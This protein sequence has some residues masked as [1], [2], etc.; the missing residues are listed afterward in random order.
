MVDRL[1]GSAVLNL[2]ERRIASDG[3][4]YTFA[5]FVAYYGFEWG[6]VM[7]QNTICLDNAEQP[8][9]ITT[10]Q[11]EP[12]PQPPARQEIKSVSYTHLTL[13]TNREV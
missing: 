9:G 10:S 12:E 4:T 1:Q 11:P 6:A 5:A 13:P 7:W 3:S 2:N 8:V